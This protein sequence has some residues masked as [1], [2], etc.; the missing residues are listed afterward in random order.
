MAAAFS[1]SASER[2]AL[3][4]IM[5]GAVVALAFAMAVAASARATALVGLIAALFVHEVRL[6]GGVL[7]RRVAASMAV[8][9]GYLFTLVLQL[10][11]ADSGP[12]QALLS[13]SCSSAASEPLPSR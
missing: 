1:L 12:T 11:S 2:V 5:V 10:S 9:V 4:S 6:D 8:C 3:D 7:L 13:S